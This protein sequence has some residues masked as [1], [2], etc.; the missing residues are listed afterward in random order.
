M[1]TPMKTAEL[2]AEVALLDPVDRLRLRKYLELANYQQ[3]ARVEQQKRLD[4]A[5]LALTRARATRDR[6]AWRLAQ[7]K[8][9][10]R[11]HRRA[12]GLPVL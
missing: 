11:E 4:D 12:A 5:D 7:M 3:R 8:R 10:H 1:K 2:L 9:Q 6:E